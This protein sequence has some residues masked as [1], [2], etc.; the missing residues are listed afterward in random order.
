MVG[1]LAGLF[2][3]FIS[4]FVAGGFLAHLGDRITAR[5]RLGHQ[6]MGMVFLGAVTSLPELAAGVGAAGVA[7]NAD[8]AYGDVVGS[9]VFNLL[10][11]GVAD[12][13]S[14]QP[15]VAVSGR[16]T[17]LNAASGVVLLSVA[18]FGPLAAGLGLPTSAWVLDLVL[19]AVYLLSLEGVRRVEAG[20]DHEEQVL[21]GGLPRLW[22][23]FSLTAL[24]VI[25]PGLWLPVLAGNL[26]L[27]LGI[28]QSFVGT[29][30][31]GAFTSAPEAMVTYH[32]VRK[33]WSRMAVGNLLGSNLFN[34]LI[35]VPMSAVYPPGAFYQAA[36]REHA[37]TALVG[38]TMTAVVISAGVWRRRQD[39]PPRLRLEGSVLIALYLLAFYA[40]AP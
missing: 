40:L 26:A 13:M 33:G 22:L 19:A 25:G 9:C 36:G 23:L 3:C 37:V 34:I 17:I 32:C 30:L 5:S 31:V 39:T 18:A 24:L 12:L 14:R 27:H 6:L 11:L 7:A 16:A 4:I 10:I 1:T 29:F 38:I 15:V 8:L 35:L 21:Q 28:S 20:E 2:F